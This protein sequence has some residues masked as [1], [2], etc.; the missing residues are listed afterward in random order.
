MAL[1][2]N[3]IDKKD[4]S[5]VIS[6][7]RNFLSKIWI[8]LGFV[9]LAEFVSGGISF[10]V[11]ARKGN[12][13]DST[14]QFV[15]AGAVTDFLPGTVTLIRSAN[16]Y[17]VQLNNGGLLAISRKCTHLG[18]AVPWVSERN[19]FECP[20]HASIFDITGNVIKSP[21]PRAL[22]LYSISFDQDRIRINISK[23]IKRTSFTAEQLVYPQER[24]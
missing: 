14:A 9:A 24:V 2:R 12:S 19:Q 5:Q 15:E 1:V 16:C 8:G 10:F 11:S 18:C 17:L 13:D 7:R 6:G 22:D 4:S 3:M 21:A 23:P 20:C